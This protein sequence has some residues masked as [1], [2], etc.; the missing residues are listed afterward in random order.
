MVFANWFQLMDYLHHVNNDEVVEHYNR[1]RFFDFDK[2]YG[3]G[4][5]T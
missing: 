5:L 3:T 1:W 2:V 4:S